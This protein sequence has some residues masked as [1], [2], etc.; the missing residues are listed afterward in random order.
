MGVATGIAF[1]YHWQSFRGR[2]QRHDF[3]DR[4]LTAKIF[5]F[6]T[7]EPSVAAY[8]LGIQPYRRIVRYAGPTTSSFDRVLPHQ[9]KG[10][11]QQLFPRPGP[12]AR[13]RLWTAAE[14]STWP[15]R[16]KA[17]AASY[18]SSPDCPRPSSFSA[19]AA[20]WASRSCPAT[21][22]ILATS[23]ALLHRR[24]GSGT[25]PPLPR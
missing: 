8:H 4:H 25:G 23:S 17:A 3:Q 1:E 22:P 14:I 15:R 12:P 19:A 11:S 13:H 7:L 20:L 6:A 16:I 18:A 5:V 21:A 9:P 24:L 10:R 2:P